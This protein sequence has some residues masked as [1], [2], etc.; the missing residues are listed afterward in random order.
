MLLIASKDDRGF[1]V[2]GVGMEDSFDA[3]EEQ[4]SLENLGGEHRRDALANHAETPG[5]PMAP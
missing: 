3:V 1:G 4:V 5:S 2:A